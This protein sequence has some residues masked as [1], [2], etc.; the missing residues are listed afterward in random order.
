MKSQKYLRLFWLVLLATSLLFL[1][2]GI[3]RCVHDRNYIETEARITDVYMVGTTPDSNGKYYAEYQYEADGITY[4][5]KK[6]IF[7]SFGKFEG[8]NEI[9]RYD[10]E[11]PTTLENTLL[12]A[13]LFTVF[14]FL[15]LLTALLTFPAW[16]K[17]GYRT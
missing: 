12:K 2:L 17:R 14:A 5:G 13:T 15:S 8:K 7:N 6:Q 11:D 1:I 10:P 3:C 4:T 9:V 16:K